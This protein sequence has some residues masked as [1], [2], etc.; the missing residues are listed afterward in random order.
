MK[1]VKVTEVEP[2]SVATKDEE[3]NI[4]VALMEDDP[5]MLEY[6]TY[7]TLLAVADE[8]GVP[9]LALIKNAKD[10]FAYL[11]ATEMEQIDFEHSEIW[12]GMEY[13]LD[14]LMEAQEDGYEEELDEE[15]IE[16]L[17]HH[18]FM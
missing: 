5:K 18:L 13:Y 3:G 14:G 4:R 8:M 9:L 16:T 10:F 6:L 12:D 2:V 17:R 15:D 7:Q 1:K 11:Y